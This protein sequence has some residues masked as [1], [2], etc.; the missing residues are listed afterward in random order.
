MEV[1]SEPKPTAE[2]DD[3]SAEER[4][5]FQDVF[6]QSSLQP[7]IVLSSTNAFAPTEVPLRK[8]SVFCGDIKL[9]SLATELSNPTKTIFTDA[10]AMQTKNQMLTRKV[11]EKNHDRM[12]LQ[13]KL[14]TDY[15][16]L[17]KT[18]YKQMTIL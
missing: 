18:L 6:D 16:D 1:D 2:A 8:A 3:E 12:E 17:R 5:E 7:D 10:N 11:V 13:G 15:Y 14:S 9:S 4:A